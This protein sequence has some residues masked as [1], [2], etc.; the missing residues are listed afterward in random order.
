[1][2]PDKRAALKALKGGESVDG[3]ELVT[4]EGARWR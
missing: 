3:F 4:S 1:V 2:S